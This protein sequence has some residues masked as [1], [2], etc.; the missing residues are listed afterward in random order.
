ML[1]AWWLGVGVG[2]VQNVGC[3]M[4]I[5][6]FWPDMGTLPNWKFNWQRILSEVSPLY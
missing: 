4:L 2:D 3:A 5:R 1:G 6:L